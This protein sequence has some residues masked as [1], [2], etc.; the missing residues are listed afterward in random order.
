M[1][2]DKRWLPGRTELSVSSSHHPADLR[3]PGRKTQRGTSCCCSWGKCCHSCFS[4]PSRQPECS[5][6]CSFDSPASDRVHV[7]SGW[8]KWQVSQSC[9]WSSG[10]SGVCSLLHHLQHQEQK[11]P[12]QATKTLAP[13]S[14]RL[15]ILCF[16]WSI[17]FISYFSFA[18]KIFGMPK[19]NNLFI[20]EGYTVVKQKLPLL[21]G[22]DWM[23]IGT[24]IVHTVPWC[25]FFSSS[26]S[27]PARSSLRL[28][29]ITGYAKNLSIQ[30]Y[31]GFPKF[32]GFS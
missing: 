13:T 23:H 19:C 22:F 21:T 30:C 14:Y 31:G 15:I 6:S 26:F 12:H 10:V 8:K 28:I 24:I 1:R 18:L 20:S 11:Q 2:R 5:S 9:Y 16:F 3:A 32:K 25:V 17:Y 7:C 27:L 4:V 29:T